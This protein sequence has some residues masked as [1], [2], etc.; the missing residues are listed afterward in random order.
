VQGHIQS[1][2]KNRC[3]YVRHLGIQMLLTAVRS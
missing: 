1:R 2:L 3:G